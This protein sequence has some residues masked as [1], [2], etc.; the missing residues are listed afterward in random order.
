MAKLEN[1][2]YK[3]AQGGYSFIT[4]TLFNPVTL[5][6]K[7]EIARD[8][9]EPRNDNDTIYYMP[10][11]EDALRAWRSHNGVVQVGDRVRVSKGRK[12]PVGTEFEV[13]EIYPMS[14]KYG[15]W[16][17]NYAYFVGGGKC[18]VDNLEI[19]ACKKIS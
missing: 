18:N 10:I 15:R 17:A 14:D 4:A 1:R 16:V 3:V 5:E 12:Y 6:S 11:D 9:D 2:W 7:H 19:V 8:Y 13:R